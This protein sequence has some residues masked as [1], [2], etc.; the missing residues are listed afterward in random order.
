MTDTSK[1]AF[2]IPPNEPRQI[3][4]TGEVGSNEWNPAFG[5]WSSDEFGIDS[6]EPHGTGERLFVNRRIYDALSARITDLERVLDENADLHS[7]LDVANLAL[8]EALA[9]MEAGQVVRP[10]EWELE[11]FAWICGDYAVER[12]CP[13]EEASV[14]LGDRLLYVSGGK[15]AVQ[16]RHEREIMHNFITPPTD[17]IAKSVEAER[18]RAASAVLNAQLQDHYDEGGRIHFDDLQ[19]FFAAAIRARGE[20]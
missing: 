11:H 6:D 2:E 16:A 18:E 10:L 19:E 4:C 14:R 20:G 13:D 5:T 12:D 7:K 17:A 1:E 9:E 3:V 8:A 15:A